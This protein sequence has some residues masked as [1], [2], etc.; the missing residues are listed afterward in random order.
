M[1][2]FFRKSSEAPSVTGQIYI[3]M[4]GAV[5]NGTVSMVNY[6]MPLNKVEKSEKHLLVFIANNVKK[7]GFKI[8]L[9]KCDFCVATDIKYWITEPLRSLKQNF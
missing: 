3:R 7:S 9:Q 4:L 8:F 1:T 2:I 6:S 5:V